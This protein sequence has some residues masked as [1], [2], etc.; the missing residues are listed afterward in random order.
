VRALEMGDE[1]V[2]Y[3]EQ[4]A[5][6]S[7]R[8]SVYDA[9]FIGLTMDR[10]RLYERVDERVDAMVAAGLL[11]EVRG[12]LGAGLRDALTA[13]QAIGYKEFVPVIEGD[14]SLD[15]AANYVHMLGI[16]D[17]TGDFKRLMRLYLVLHSDHESG[18][19]SAMTTATVNSAPTT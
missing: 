6:F 1:G 19:V 3:A 16:P 12:L 15:W 17:P 18:N 2:S 13:S 7:A 14:A 8:T 5:G 4:R 10:A 9:R 11:D